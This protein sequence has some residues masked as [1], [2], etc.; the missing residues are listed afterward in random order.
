MEDAR[1]YNATRRPREP[2]LCEGRY[3]AIVMQL[4]LDK[5]PVRREHKAVEEC[6]GGL[7]RR[8]KY[9]MDMY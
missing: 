7:P 2:D 6:R 5:K 1:S 9:E 3:L 8:F 4:K